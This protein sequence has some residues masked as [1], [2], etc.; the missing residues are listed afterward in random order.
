MYPAKNRY[1]PVVVAKG[2][3]PQHA[4]VWKQK[5]RFGLCSHNNYDLREA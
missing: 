2:Y 3:K 1:L 4:S 5:R